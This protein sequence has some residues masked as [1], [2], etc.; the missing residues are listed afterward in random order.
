M[1]LVEWISVKWLLILA[2]ASIWT[3]Y[4]SMFNTPRVRGWRNLG[5][6]ACFIIGAIMLFV[7]PWGSA[8]LT[9]AVAATKHGRLCP[10]PSSWPMPSLSGPSC[11]PEAIEYFLADVG[12]LKSRAAAD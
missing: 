11:F 6:L 3:I 12:A 7:L 9:W 10:I 4:F 2:C 1:T 8:L 5:W